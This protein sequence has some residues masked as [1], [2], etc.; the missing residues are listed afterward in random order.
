[1]VSAALVVGEADDR[2]GERVVAHVV[3]RPGATVDAA[4]LISHCADH[5]ARYK[6]PARIVLRED[7]PTTATG[8][9]VRRLLS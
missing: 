5:V 8:K 6:V 7:L 9:T 3:P 1:M 4:A 2:S